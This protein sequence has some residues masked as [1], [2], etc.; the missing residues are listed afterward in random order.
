MEK[1]TEADM[2]ARLNA[3]RGYLDDIRKYHVPDWKDIREFMLPGW[4]L[5]DDEDPSQ[6]PD[7]GSIVDDSGGRSFSN[8]AAGMYTGLSSPSK[9]WV[10]LGLEDKELAKSSGAKDWLDSLEK[11]VYGIYRRSNFY[12]ACYQT[13]VE[14]GFGNAAHIILEHPERAIHSTVLTCGEYWIDVGSDGL[15]NRIIRQLWL[16]AIVVA[17]EFGIDKLSQRLQTVL[18]KD[19]RTGNPYLRTRLWHMIKPRSEYDPMRMDALNMPY[20]SYYWEDG[21]TE[22]ILREG[23]YEEFPAMV[24]RWDVSGPRIYGVGPLHRVLGDVMML[25][26]E[27]KALLKGGQKVI[28]PPMNA[29]PS[30]QKRVSHIP[31]G[32]NTVTPGEMD[33]LK[34]TYQVAP[35]LRDFREEVLDTRMAIREG[36]YNDLFLMLQKPN[37]TATEVAE[38]HSEKLQ[39]LGPTIERQLQEFLKPAVY[40]T[41]NI[42]IRNGMVPPPPKQIQGANMRIEFI[43]I[44]AQAQKLVGTQA[45]QTGA[46]F[47]LGIGKEQAA[48]GR[49]P[50]VLDNA[51]F[52]EAARE[53]MEMTGVPAGMIVPK[54]R[55]EAIRKNRAQI[56]AQREQQMMQAQ[57][58]ATAKDLA[59]TPTDGQNALTELRQAVAE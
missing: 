59:N 10:K 22:H 1:M 38:R 34:P 25:Q 49:D 4:G 17:E 19:K 37:M 36:L 15:V 54:E 52:D 42:A 41:V 12:R 7:Y 20:A 11:V 33:V 57:Q 5:F 44:L 23:G 3:E 18:T 30:Y 43:S 29:P 45:I 6:A 35:N 21:Q 53:Y 28:D 26:E 51:D 14:L 39:M 56:M 27:R 40:R 8:L 16:P 24:S 46:S 50:D 2:V 55:V 9:R 47:V 32:M 48:M 31:G 13:Y 58:A